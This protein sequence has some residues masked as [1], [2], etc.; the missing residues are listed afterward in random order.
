[1]IVVLGIGNRLRGDDGIGSIVAQ[2]LKKYESDNLIVYDCE[3]TP[4][5]YIDKVI[6]NNPDWVIFIDACNFNAPVGS[7]RL[8]EEKEVSK[9]SGAFVSTHTLP[10]TVSVALIKTNLPHTRISLL[11]I[12]PER[13]NFSMTLSNKLRQSKN[14]IINFL[15][16][17]LK[18]S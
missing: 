7:F 4:E 12:Q 10:L 5:N 17:L 13:L 3:T 2:E 15:L 6:S 1:M 11:G 16:K 8:F 9:L 18:E 14:E